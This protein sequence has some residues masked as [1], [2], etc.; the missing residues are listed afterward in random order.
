MLPEVD[1]DIYQVASGLRSPIALS[2]A[3]LCATLQLGAPLVLFYVNFQRELEIL[4]EPEGASESNWSA[5]VQTREL[6]LL[7]FLRIIF[8][9]Y[10]LLLEFR[11]LNDDGLNLTL[12][13][14]ALPEF[15]TAGLFL[16]AVL[17]LTA[18][19]L[20]SAC[21]VLLMVRCRDSNHGC[22]I[23]TR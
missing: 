18:R 10:N 14:V 13:L 15:S 17:N 21:I 20:I 12:F 9:L 3:V 22:R 8:V 11:Q 1:W 16:G 23:R 19:T 6:I 5:I 4:R 7:G 2:A